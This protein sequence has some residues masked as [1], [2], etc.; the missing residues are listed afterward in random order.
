M[1]AAMMRPEVASAGGWRPG[2]GLTLNFVYPR[3]VTTATRDGNG[4]VC[5]YCTVFIAR[6]SEPV[7]GSELDGCFVVITGQ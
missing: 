3:W 6:L 1:M 4:G 2:G 7:A 5:Y